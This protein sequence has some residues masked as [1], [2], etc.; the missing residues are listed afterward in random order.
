M[1]KTPIDYDIV[2]SVID[3]FNLPDFGKATIREIVAITNKIEALTGQR[4]VRMEMGVPG[5]DAVQIGVEDEIEAL[6]KGVASKY[7]ML[8]GLPAL[9][10]EASRFIKAFIDADVSL[11]S[12]VP[13]VGSMQGT[14]ASFLVAGQCDKKKDTILF[15][16]PGFPV[17][18]QQLVVLGYKYESFDA[19]DCRGGKLVEKV[20]SFLKKGNI[21]AIIYSNPNNPSWICLQDFE[22]EG[23]GHLAT[24][25]DAIVMEDLAYFAMDFRKNLS[26]PFEPPFQASVSKYTDNYILLISSSKAF[27]YA[28]QRIGIV[29]ISDTLYNRK[30]KDLEERYHVSEFGNVFVNRVL[31]S[32][33]SG[34]CHSAQYA[35]AAMFKAA[36]DGTLD[37]L[38]EV[39]VYADRA[40]KVKKMFTENGF[41]IVYAYDLNEQ[42]GDGFYFTIRYPSM[43]GAVLMEKLIYYGISAISLETTGSH[44]EG[45][46][47][48][49]SFIQNDQYEDL[50]YRIQRFAK[51]HPL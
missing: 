41:E 44:Q 38:G 36:N 37:F 47:V 28:G 16:D 27:S 40:E 18:K 9:K 13:V 21:A 12:C 35:L 17:Q 4:F 1:D 10:K 20:E 30:Y 6:R 50:A 48:C 23:I 43:T 2:K 29:A 31:Y 46:R 8:D 14:Y 7:P 24:K 45:L 15:I 26:K 25:Y 5:L 19:F 33:S 11:T 39:K 34:T 51:N 49:T 42:I 22:L 3:S 32:L